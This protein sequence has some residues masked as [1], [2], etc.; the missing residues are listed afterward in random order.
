MQVLHQ[1]TAEAHKKFLETQIEA[2]RT[3]QAMMEKTKRLAEATLG[4][5]IEIDSV[6]SSFEKKSA[7]ETRP[8]K[9]SLHNRSVPFNEH[10]DVQGSVSVPTIQKKNR[11]GYR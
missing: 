7:Q 1:Q 8:A 11:G 3:L 6:D 5:K 4:H 2:S 9:D 10:N